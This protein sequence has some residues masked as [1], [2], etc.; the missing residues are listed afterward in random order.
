MSSCVLIGARGSGKTKVG[1]ELAGMLSVPF[2]DADVLFCEQQGLT[3][4]DFVAQNGWPAFREEETSL[5]ARLYATHIHHRIV[6]AAGGGAVAH[7]QGDAYRMR[8]RATVRAFGTVIYLLPHSDLRK[9][10]EILVRR[11]QE[12]PLS[13]SMRPALQAGA[14]E[15]DP[16]E[17]MYAQLKQRDPLYADAACWTILT[18]DLVPRQIAQVIAE[19]YY[20]HGS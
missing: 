13:A 7:D 20:S 19:K 8:N 9:S 11:Q 3:I 10:A 12:D 6:L 17:A 18:R 5:L 2:I 14:Q 1:K 16:V 15:A 4:A